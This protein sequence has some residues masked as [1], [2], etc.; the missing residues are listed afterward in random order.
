MSLRFPCSP[1]WGKRL[2]DRG[3]CSDFD[4]ALPHPKILLASLRKL[5]YDI[6]QCRAKIAQLVEHSPE[7]AGVPGSSPG[8]GTNRSKKSFPYAWCKIARLSLFERAELTILNQYLY[9]PSPTFRGRSGC[10]DGTVSPGNPHPP[11]PSPVWGE[12]TCSVPLLPA[13]RG[14]GDRAVACNG[15]PDEMGNTRV[16][17]C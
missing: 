5:C 15:S 8:L 14:W 10:R 9:P 2:G 13:V 6:H 16:Y 7:K 12:N 3:G 17:V 11:A 4:V 1:Q